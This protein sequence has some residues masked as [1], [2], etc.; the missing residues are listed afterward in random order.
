[1]SIHRDVQTNFTQSELVSL[2]SYFSGSR[3]KT[4]ISTRRRTPAMRNCADGDDLVPDKPAIASLVQTMLVAPPTPEPS[5]DA[6]ALAVDRRRRH[7]A[8][9][10]RTAAA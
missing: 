3:S 8:S 2:A 9:T 7:C 10:S 5:P 6:M 4:F 1:M